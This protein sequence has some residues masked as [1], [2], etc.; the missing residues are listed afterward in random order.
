[1]SRI[2]VNDRIT[3]GITK[4][5]YTDEGFLTVP[6]RVARTGIQEYL[7][8]ELGI[9]DR[10]PN[11][12]IKVYRPAE[13][14]FHPD[15]L[16]S[17]GSS[18]VTIEHPTEMVN[19]DTYNEVSAGVV[20][21]SGVQDGD[22]VLANLIVKSKDAIEAIETGK[23]QLSAGYT[24]IYDDTPGITEDGEK[25]D[26]VQRDIKINHV[27]L[28]DR[29]RAGA[30][31]RLFDNNHGAVNMFKVTLDSKRTV[32]IEDSATATLVEDSIARLTKQAFDAD[33][34]ATKAE[35][36]KDAVKEELEEEK[37]KSSDSAISKRVSEIATVIDSARKIAGKT[38]SCDS[39]D[40]PTIQRAAL[41]IARDSVDWAD[42][43]DLY[44]GIA[45][46]MKV[47]KEA[48]DEEVEA[49]DEEAEEKVTDS[50]RKLAN[51]GADKT[52]VKDSAPAKTP[53]QI[54]KDSQA[55]AHKGEK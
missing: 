6:G 10:E 55:N 7:A 33:E 19:A 4:R 31:A 32:D 51:D 13:E 30:Q 23:V 47:E 36:E 44:V 16:D 53:Y 2:A 48:E 37:K 15:S 1:M 52:H 42:K 26:F 9:T 14:V 5:E 45:F 40:V 22:F 28:V 49:E 46:D 20:V 29:A 18:D 41:T 21:G 34:K 12:L 43:N 39:M 11:D 27:A 35:A 24:A 8:S 54:F 17:Y 3:Y 38:F 25:Y 50:Y